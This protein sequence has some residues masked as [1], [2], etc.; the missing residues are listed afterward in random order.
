[1]VKLKRRWICKRD[2]SKEKEEK[3]RREKARLVSI[4]PASQVSCALHQLLVL[5]LLHLQL[6][7]S[8]DRNGMHFT[9][10]GLAFQNGNV[11]SVLFELLLD[12]VDL[13]VSQ[14]VLEWSG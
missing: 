5:V 7:L 4:Q 11:A 6:A 8:L 14:T 9:L 13:A 3:N 10:A 1:V 2:R 12:V